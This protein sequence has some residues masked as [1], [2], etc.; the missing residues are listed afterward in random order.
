MG[1][2]SRVANGYLS[3]PQPF[4]IHLIKFKLHGQLLRT[5]FGES[6]VDTEL[7]LFTP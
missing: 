6:C 4:T 5:Y 7:V 2:Q 3:V 1:T